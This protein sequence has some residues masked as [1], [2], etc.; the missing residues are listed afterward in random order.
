MDVQ[1]PALD[2]AMASFEGFGKPGTLATQN[3]NPGNIIA[4]VFADK[5]GSVGTNNGFAVFPDVMTGTQA[6]DNLMSYYANQGY[7]VQSMLSKYAPANAPGNSQS[8]LQ[9]YIDYVTGKTGS[10]ADTPVSAL[11]TP[12]ADQAASAPVTGAGGLLSNTV[13]VLGGVVAAATGGTGTLGTAGSRMIGNTG[14]PW[15]RVAAG[16]LGLICIAGAIYLYKPNASKVAV[17][18]APSLAKVAL[19]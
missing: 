11:K 14:L 10:T 6:Q 2:S 19:A 15:S 8:S 3:N 7:T 5:N 13:K 1:F 18:L 12:L 17:G 4:G 9:N 16:L